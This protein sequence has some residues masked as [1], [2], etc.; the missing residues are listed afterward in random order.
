MSNRLGKGIE[1]LIRT[2]DLNKD[3]YLDG[4]IKI[5]KIKI[6]ADQPR[7]YF[8]EKSLN[9]LVQSI[10]E[11]GILQPITLKSIDNGEFELIA[12]ERRFRA[13]KILNLET[14]P[15]YVIKVDSEAEKLELA[16]IENVQRNDLNV[17]E[18]AEAY[19]ILKER[20]NLTHEQIAQKIGKSR[21]EITRTMEL[22]KLPDN[23][24][25]LL[26]ENANNS[27]FPFSRGHARTILALKDS[28]KIQSLFNRILKEKLSVRK[29]EE[30]VKKINGSLKS[31]K[32]IS[33][34]VKSAI[35]DERLL[36]GLLNAKIEISNRKNNSGHIKIIFKSKEDREKI[37]Q[38]I[39]SIKKWNK[40]LCNKFDLVPKFIHSISY[41]KQTL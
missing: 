14:V 24:K 26:V 31:G 21:V 13:A 1:A 4:F 27:E 8:D 25:Q 23:I 11:K 34:Q 22:I 33:T 16:L 5:D 20:Y 29:T 41:E 38:I 30:L 12:G 35:D 39:K 17:I 18:E 36:S 10:K 3:E 6:N 15:A 2:R 28:I 32:K 19:S 9:E 37:I 7:K 40:N